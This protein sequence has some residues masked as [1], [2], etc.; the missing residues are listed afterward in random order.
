MKLCY[1]SLNVL[2][3]SHKSIVQKCLPMYWLIHG[4]ALL[5]KWNYQRNENKQVRQRYFFFFLP[6]GPSN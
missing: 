4:Y 3:N 5:N 2:E 1:L 6:P